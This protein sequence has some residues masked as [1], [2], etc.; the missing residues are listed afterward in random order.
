MDYLRDSYEFIFEGVFNNLYFYRFV[1]TGE[2]D[3]VKRIGFSPTGIGGLYSLGFGNLEVVNGKTII[4]DKSLINNKDYNQVLS[5]VFSCIIH[6]ISMKGSVKVIFYGNTE[7]K[8]ILYLRKISAYYNSLKEVITV[9]GGTLRDDV[10]IRERKISEKRIV[11][12]KD[13]NDVLFDISKVDKIEL[14]NVSNSKK[15]KF[16]IIGNK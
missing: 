3:I 12:E 14:F 13:L 6:F 7:H 5:T 15:Y 4:D 1:S 16:I 9:Y 8:H 11:R 2:R 10:L